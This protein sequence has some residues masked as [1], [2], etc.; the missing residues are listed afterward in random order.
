MEDVLKV[1]SIEAESIVVKSP[2]SP[3]QVAI[4]ATDAATLVWLKSEKGSA[5]GLACDKTGQAFVV[6]WSDTNNDLPELAIIPQKGGSYIQLSDGN[7]GKISII[8]FADLANL[9]IGKE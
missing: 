3:G 5:V 8:K 7:W 1:K 9:V 6:A 2:N 4:T